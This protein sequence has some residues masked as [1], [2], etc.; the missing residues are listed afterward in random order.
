MPSSTDFDAI[1][2]GSGFGGSVCAFRLAS[3]GARVLVL[4]RGRRWS[5]A[6][7]PRK[8]DDPW[9]W[10]VRQPEKHH[11]WFDFR[12][13]PNMTVVQGAGVGGGSLVYAN[14]SVNAKKETFNSGWPPEIRFDELQDYYEAV[15]VTMNV[16][17]VPTNQWP[18]RT[19]LL[20]DAANAA[21]YGNRFR[22][23]DLAVTFDDTWNYGLPNPHDPQRSKKA[24]NAFGV[25]QGTCVHLGNCDIGC[26]VNARNTLDLNYLAGAEQHHAEVRPLHLVRTVAPVS[27]GYEVRYDEI[28]DSGTL[29]PGRATARI[30]VIAAGS[31]GSTELLLQSRTAGLLPDISSRLGQGWSSNGDFL[32]PALHFFRTVNPTRGPT[33]TGAIDLLDGE[34]NGKEIFVEDGGL[35][36][37]ARAWLQDLVTHDAADPKEARVIASILPLLSGGQFLEHVMP[38]FAQARD[39]ADGRLSLKNGQ[40]WLDWDVS[41]SRETIDAVAAVHRK[42]AFLTEGMPLTPVTWTIGHDLITPHPLG[43][44]NMGRSSADG[45]VDHLGQVFNYPNLYVADGAIVPKAIGLNPSKTIAALAERIAK[46]LVEKLNAPRGPIRRGRRKPDKVGSQPGKRRQRSTPR[47]RMRT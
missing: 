25:E 19:K 8:P 11:G 33:I 23:L 41:A 24:P 43:G 16:G 15:R 34:F 9:I 47:R 13:F 42:L 35:P 26:D 30:V 17:P 14:I 20:H 12:I 4:E 36:D 37:V 22:R 18:E 38:W 46:G 28:S 32:T 7:F 1:I 5:P 3:A 10:D 21:G 6:T 40:L 2:V 29:S 44:C 39:A 27:G 31:L 45:V